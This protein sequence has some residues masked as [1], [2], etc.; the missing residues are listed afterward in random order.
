[1]KEWRFLFNV[2]GKALLLF[3]AV[4]L[5]FVGIYPSGT[6]GKLSLYNSLFPGRE[7]FPFGENSEK[8]YNLSL[9]NLDAMF[10]SHLISQ[11]KAQDEFRIILIGDSATW[12]TLLRPQET[13]AG[14]LQAGLESAHPQQN[15]QVYNLGYPTLSLVKDLLILDQAMAYQPD[16]ILWLTTLESF[17]IDR[18]LDSPLVQQNAARVMELEQKYTVKLGQLPALPT[19]WQANLIT[20][21]RNLADLLSLQLYGFMWGAT[22]IDQEYFTDYV[23]AQVDLD[24]DE[25]FEGFSPPALPADQMAFHLLDL[26]TKIAGDTRMIIIN[27][28]ILISGGENH[29]LRYNFYYPR[30]AYDQ[31]RQMFEDEC[32]SQGWICYDYWDLLKPEQFTNSAI[33]P[34]A[35]GATDFARGLQSDLD[36]LGIIP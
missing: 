36:G 21:R 4:N 35:Q 32:T 30:W 13:L 10:A 34:S 28:P 8:S 14:Q 29:E 23:P 24:A 19:Q 5:L 33:H 31:Y 9:S 1:M 6:G 17:P 20:Q 16:L 12:G 18:Q 15:I 11:P 26:G 2:L 7:R 27:E 22:G 25:T 3:L